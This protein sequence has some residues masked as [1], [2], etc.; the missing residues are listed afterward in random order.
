[1]PDLTTLY[2]AYI[3]AL[4]TANTTAKDVTTLLAKDLPTVRAGVPADNR[5]DYNTMLA[6]YLVP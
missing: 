6:D 1:M 2:V 5:D 3:V 4:K